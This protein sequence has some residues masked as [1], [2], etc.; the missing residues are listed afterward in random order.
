MNKIMSV[1]AI[2]S[3]LFQ[4]R[5]FIAWHESAINITALR[6]QWVEETNRFENVLFENILSDD[7]ESAFYQNGI[8]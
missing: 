8:T 4:L 1:W 5:L 7:S 6:L 2:L 3:H